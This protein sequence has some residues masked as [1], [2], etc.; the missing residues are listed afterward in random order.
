MTVADIAKGAYVSW[1]GYLFI[2]LGGIGETGPFLA[3]SPMCSAPTLTVSEGR[4]NSARVLYTGS[5][6]T[7][8]RVTL[9]LTSSGMHGECT[10][11]STSDP[12]LTSIVSYQDEKH[13]SALVQV[14]ENT[15]YTVTMKGCLASSG[16]ETIIISPEVNNYFDNSTF[17]TNNSVWDVGAIPIAGWVEVPGNPTTYGTANFLAMQYEAKYDCTGDGV[18]DTAAACSAAADSGLGLDYRD[19]SSFSA[20][21]VVST[22]EG[23]PIV[24]INHNQAMSACPLG[25]RLITNSEWMTIIRDAELQTV[26]WGNNIIG[27]TVASGGGL[28]RGNVGI[29]DSVSYD[30]AD[31]EYGLGRNTKARIEL[32]NGSHLWDLAGNVYEHVQLDENDTLLPQNKQPTLSTS[33]DNGAGTAGWGQLTEI[34]TY[35]DLSYDQIRL[36]NATYNSFYGA[37]QIWTYGDDETA[38]TSYILQRGGC[39]YNN[40]FAGLAS[41]ALVNLPTAHVNT[42]GFRC[43]A[44]DV[45]LSQTHQLDTGIEGGANEI[46]VGNLID[47]KLTQT[48]NLEDTNDYAL[49]VY[50]YDNTSGNVGGAVNESVA[51]LYVNGETVATTYTSVSDGW[52]RLSGVI[53]GANENRE[54]GLLIKSGKTIKVDNLALIDY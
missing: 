32:S 13:C 10:W 47:G 6:I 38:T 9:T 44:D 30:G 4:L 50:V 49:S 53:T 40:V 26:N 37:G 1:N 20:S 14:T 11:S 35:G 12:T 23:A 2:K 22:A 25:S 33:A 36:S 27:S 41:I 46:I 5:N 24:H 52:Y 43:V 21:N 29:T 31:P 54:Y 42:L 18:G 8:G 3:V 45:V 28:K 16:I 51:A 48:L 34:S 7:P 15:D 39:W 19:I 17:D